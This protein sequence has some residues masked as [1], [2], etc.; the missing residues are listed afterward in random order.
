MHLGANEQVNPQTG[1][2]VMRWHHRRQYHLP[3][4]GMD[5]RTRYAAHF[6]LGDIELVDVSPEVQ[7]PDF[8]STDIAPPLPDFITPVSPDIQP[9][10]FDIM[11][12]SPIASN[13]APT[14]APGTPPGVSTGGAVSS[15]NWFTSD[16]V[17]ILGLA[18]Q[19]YEATVTHMMPGVTGIG[20]GAGVLGP[21]GL[22]PAQYAAMTPAQRAAYAAQYSGAGVGLAP[23]ASDPLSAMLGGS[24]GMLLLGGVGLLAMIMLMRK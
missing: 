1:L 13:P 6:G 24:S 5:E 4:L 20:T 10:S 14:V 11:D 2:P 15:G 3:Y 16:V 9:P 12:S 8:T 21:G 23:G 17:P 22:T 7:I 19:A 18:A